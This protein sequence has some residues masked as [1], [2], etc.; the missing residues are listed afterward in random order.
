MNNMEE[1]N[2]LWK[3]SDIVIP[4]RKEPKTPS[5]SN[6]LFSPAT[7]DITG[8]L[9][10]IGEDLSQ[11]VEPTEPEKKLDLSKAIHIVELKGRPEHVE[12]FK[13]IAQS[14]FDDTSMGSVETPSG[15]PVGA[16]YTLIGQA[17]KAFPDLNL[18]EDKIIVEVKIKSHCKK[19]NEKG[20]IGRVFDPKTYKITERL[21][22]CSC[23]KLN[24]DIE[25]GKEKDQKDDSAN[26]E[27]E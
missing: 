3:Q 14:Q 10:E 6:P 24:I 26:S 20:Y 1:N 15:L 11:V 27:T 22:K 17:Q 4:D 25:V 13:T 7:G 19:C 18:T 23:L 5:G 8:G 2:N 16:I 21:M 9:D 12:K